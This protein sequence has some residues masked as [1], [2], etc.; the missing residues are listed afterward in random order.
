M[1][2][3]ERLERETIPHQGQKITF[4]TK[5]IEEL[6]QLIN[7]YHDKPLKVKFEPIRHKRSHDANAYMWVLADEIAKT[8]N[9][10]KKEVY[11]RA[12]KEVGVYSDLA[13]RRQD[14]KEFVRWW[15]GQGIGYMVD[16]FDSGLADNKGEP[17][18]RIRAYLGSSK[19]DTK[20]MSRLIDWIV[21]EAKELGI[22]TETPEE[23]ARIKALWGEHGSITD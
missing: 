16:I 15:T 23:I 12:V 18:K 4:Y 22:P 14:V 10:T 2:K 17:M 6:D 7:K 13:V 3:V 5:D 8:I 9:S 20:Q 19:Y 1:I 11:R 21:E